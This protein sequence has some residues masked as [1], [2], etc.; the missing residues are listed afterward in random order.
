MIGSARDRDKKEE[1]QRR[2]FKVKLRHLL[3]NILNLLSLQTLIQEE[4]EAAIAETKKRK[5]GRSTKEIGRSKRIRACYR[6]NEIYSQVHLLHS[7]FHQLILSVPGLQRV[8]RF[9]Q[10]EVGGYQRNRGQANFR[11]EVR[12]RE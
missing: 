3:S 6:Q 7:S 2:S 10:A 4:G 5:N 8:Q 11:R 9:H 12:V 1:P